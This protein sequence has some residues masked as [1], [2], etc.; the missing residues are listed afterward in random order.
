MCRLQAVVESL[1]DFLDHF[2]CRFR[3]LA[4]D[5]INDTIVKSHDIVKLP[6]PDIE[7]SLFFED[8]DLG[9]DQAKLGF[10]PGSRGFAFC[11]GKSFAKSGQPASGGPNSELS[12]RTLSW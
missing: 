9:Q 2:L 10:D 1:L 4:L 7:G 6:Q 5:K 8:P 11:E 3:V 12:A